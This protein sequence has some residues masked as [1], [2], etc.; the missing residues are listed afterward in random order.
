MYMGKPKEKKKESVKVRYCPLC[1]RYLKEGVYRFNDSY[2]PDLP[3]NIDDTMTCLEVGIKINKATAKAYMELA[4]KYKMEM[5]E[6][7][8]SLNDDDRFK[9]EEEL[10][11]KLEEV[12]KMTL[13]ELIKMMS[14]NKQ[15]LNIFRKQRLAITDMYKSSLELLACVGG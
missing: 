12:S 6:E 3:K 7:W 15:K 4:E 5:E 1:D 9:L 10:G 8:R 14:E 11:I 2:C 13:K